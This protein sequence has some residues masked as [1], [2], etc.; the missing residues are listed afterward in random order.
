MRSW[1]QWRERRPQLARTKGAAAV[2]FSIGTTVLASSGELGTSAATAC[3]CLKT[4]NSKGL[5]TK[6]VIQK[7]RA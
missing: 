6:H 2:V 7:M 1:S 5:L 4:L 3:D